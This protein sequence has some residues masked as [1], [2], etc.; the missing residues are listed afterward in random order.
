MPHH[1]QNTEQVRS[2]AIQ[3]IISQIPNWLVRWGT[4]L[5][6]LILVALFFL[7]WVIHYPDIVKAPLMITTQTIPKSVIAHS[8]GRLEKLY[9]KDKQYVKQGDVL[10][11]LENTANYQ[12]I[13]NLSSYLEKFHTQI[14]QNFTQNIQHNPPVCNNLGSLQNDFEN[15]E[16]ARMQVKAF[17]GSGY[18]PQRERLLEKDMQEVSKLNQNLS[19]QKQILE[20]DYAIVKN[21]YEVHKQLNEQ[22]VVPILELKKIESRMLAKELPLKQTESSII[23][24]ETLINSKKGELLE[25]HKNFS[26]KSLSLIQTLNVLRNNLQTWKNLYLLT[27]PQNGYVSFASVIQENIQVNTNQPLFKIGDNAQEIFGIVQISQF[28]SGKVK[29]GQVVNVKFS[30]YPFQEYG[31]VQ[32]KIISISDI[33]S[34]DSTFFAKIALPQDLSTNYGKKIAFRNGMSALAEIIT[35]DN[36]L[37]ERYIY[38]MRKVFER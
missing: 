27:A 15:F 33:S 18:Y 6:F 17:L 19:Q 31:M 3:E 8:T 30:G 4:T 14:N 9:V 25:I 16:I 37:I 32:G 11:L 12:E 36:R 20:N 24:N 34:S 38:Q 2:E 29:V 22:K 10:G 1:A 5:F 7:S 26:D 28:S 21:E 35:E 23:N 13:N